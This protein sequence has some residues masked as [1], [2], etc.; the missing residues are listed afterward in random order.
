MRQPPL[1][2]A[3]TALYKQIAHLEAAVELNLQFKHLL[4]GLADNFYPICYVAGG[5]VFQSVWNRLHGFKIDYGLNDFDIVYY[6]PDTSWDAENAVIERLKERF[7][8]YPLDV[9]NVARAH[10]WKKDLYGREFPEAK[11]VEEGIRMFG[12]TCA[13]VGVRRSGVS[14]VIYAPFGLNDIF[15]REVVLDVR[16]AHRFTA[17]EYRDKTDSWKRRWPEIKVHPH[18]YG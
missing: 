15:A 12:I 7:P 18:P 9:K 14:F 2:V 8:D 4:E 6:D 17:D 16:A 11:S 3:D 13:A 10:L 1:E 5:A